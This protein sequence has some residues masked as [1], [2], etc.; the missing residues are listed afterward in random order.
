MPGRIQLTL[1]I[2]ADSS[3][4]KRELQG[5]Q[6]Q[7]QSISSMKMH[8]PL[9]D[10]QSDIAGGVKA[11][12]QLQAALATAVNKDTGQLNLSKFSRTL[13]EA[14]TDVAQLGQQLKQLGPVGEQAFQTLCSSILTADQSVRSLDGLFG[15]FLKGLGN[16]AMWTLQSNAIHAMQSALSGAYS[17]AQQL[18]KGLTDIAIVSDLTGN[19]LTNFAKTA[20]QM[21]KDLSASTRDVVSGAL[22][23]YQAGLSDEEVINRTETTIKLAQTSGESAEQISSYMTA[24]W[25]N[26]Y[27][28]SKSVEYYADAISYL[29]AVTAA[30]NADIAEGMQAFSAVA[31][32]VGLSFEYGASALTLLRDIT[33]QSAS[34]IGNSLKT[35]FARLS[36]V[37]QGETL[38]DGVDLTKYSQSLMNV[39]VE[40]LDA[41]G[42]LKDMDTILDDL[43]E[44]WKNLDE[45]NKVALATTVGGV[46]QYNNLISLMDNYGKFQELVTGSYQ[47]E[48][49]LEEQHAKY[50]ESWAAASDRVKAAWEQIYQLL[51]NDKALIGISNTF[52]KILD[53][54][55]G[56]LEGMGGLKGI[57][58]SILGFVTRLLDTSSIRQGVDNVWAYLNP[59]KALQEEQAM[60]A[61]ARQ[62]LAKSLR[63]E[64][65]SK[66]YNTAVDSYLASVE[67]FNKEQDK[68]T[69]YEKNL[70]QVLLEDTAQRL[71]QLQLLEEQKKVLQ[72]TIALEK[73]SVSDQKAM[74]TAATQA[75]IGQDFLNLIDEEQKDY[76]ANKFNAEGTPYSGPGITM[77]RAG[78]A[79]TFLQ[80]LDPDIAPEL[81]A[82]IERYASSL[83]KGSNKVQDSI[84]QQIK[85]WI[86]TTLAGVEARLDKYPQAQKDKSKQDTKTKTETKLDKAVANAAQETAEAKEK[87]AEADKATADANQ[88]I[89][90]QEQEKTQLGQIQKDNAEQQQQEEQ[91]RHGWLSSIVDKIKQIVS[92]ETQEEQ[93]TD[94]IV[95]NQKAMS[96]EEERQ[97]QA[98]QRRQQQQRGVASM[99]YGVAA[100]S[101]LYAYTVAFDTLLEKIKEGD[102]SISQLTGTFIG[103]AGNITNAG[104]SLAMWGKALE[105]SGSAL[106]GFLLKITSSVP[107]LLGFIAVITALYFIIKKVAEFVQ[108]QDW[109]F[110]NRL[111]KDAEEA[112]DAAAE[113]RKEY[114]Q[115]NDVLSTLKD[116]N[117]AINNLKEG[118]VEWRQAVQELNSELRELIDKY[119]LV[120]GTDFN[121]NN[122][123]IEL[124]SEGQQKLNQKQHE[125]LSEAE[126][127]ESYASVYDLLNDVYNIRKN[128]VN[129]NDAW[130]ALQ[131]EASGYQNL[132]GGTDAETINNIKNLLAQGQGS[133]ALKNAYNDYTVAMGTEALQSKLAT[134]MFNFLGENFGDL[135]TDSF[136]NDMTKELLN[137]HLDELPKNEEEVK[138]WISDILP[139]LLR[140]YAQDSDFVGPGNTP[141]KP[142]KRNDYDRG[143]A[144]LT[145]KEKENA[146]QY[147]DALIKLQDE[148]QGL[149]ESEA[150]AASKAYDLAVQYM[151]FNKG[152][153]DIKENYETYIPLLR[154]A[155]KFSGDYV[156]TV[157]EL[158]N[159]L[160]LMLDI[161]PQ[162]LSDAFFES[163]EAIDAMEKAAKGSI[164]ALQELT[165]LAAQDLLDQGFAKIHPTIMTDQL[166]EQFAALQE[167]INNSEQWN[168]LEV[169]AELKLHDE[170]FI[171][172]LNA[173]IMEAYSISEEA[174]QA[175]Y[176]SIQGA[177][178][179]IQFEPDVEMRSETV[180]TRGYTAIAGQV[181]MKQGSLQD[182]VSYM[183]NAEITAETEMVIPHIN[184]A[185]SKGPV[186]KKTGLSTPKGG[187][188]GGSKQKTK[189][190]DTNRYHEITEKI[191]QTQHALEMLNDEED[192]AYGQKKLDLIQE[193]IKL[194]EQE[195]KQYKELYKE[196]QGY[197]ASDRALLA[198]KYGA[199]F[200]EDGTI[201]NYQKWYD[202]FVDKYNSGAMD[203]DA[204]KAFEDAI[205]KYEESYKKMNEA[206]KKYQE[207]LN[208]EYDARIELIEHKLEFLNKEVDEANKHIDFLIKQATKDIYKLADAMALMSQKAGNLL[209]KSKNYRDAIV[210]MFANK[211]H[212]NVSE[213]MINAFLNGGEGAPTV[214][215]LIDAAGDLTD[216][217]I[218]LLYEYADALEEISE[219]LIE[220]REQQ[221]ATL[222]EVIDGFNE[223][224][225]RQGD[226]IND[227]TEFLKHYRNVVDIVGKDIL[228]ISDEML[229]Q[230]G[231]TAVEGAKANL[232]VAKL[233]L[234]QNK[235][236]LEQMREELERER[237]NGASEEAIRLMEEQIEAQEDRV[238]EMSENWASAWEDALQAAQDAF[239]DAIKIAT[240]AFD[241]A[242]AGSMGNLDNLQDMYEKQNTLND[243]YLPKYQQIYELNKLTRDVNNAIDNTDNIAGKERLLQ[244]QRDINDAMEEGAQVSEYDVGFMQRRLE[245][246]M[247]R[248]ALEEA[249]NA[250]N[251]VRMTRDSEGNWSY[252][253]TA[254]AQKIADA[255]QNYEDKLYELEKYN[256]EH[257]KDMQDM[258]LNLLA[259]YRDDI[260]GLN[261]TDEERAQM[262]Q[263][264]W[265]KLQSEYGVFMD[266]A[267]ND[268]QFIVDTFGVYDHQ[269]M[270][271]FED[272]ILSMT[273]GFSTLEEYLEN[274]LLASQYMMGQTS[275]A[276]SDWDGDWHSIFEI[277]GV[278]AE[279][280]AGEVDEAMA[281]FGKTMEAAVDE[282][283]RFADELDE[284]FDLALDNLKEFVDEYDKEIKK[285]VDDNQRALESIQAFI[286]EYDRLHANDEEEEEEPPKTTTPTTQPGTGGS[287]SGGGGGGGSGSGGGGGDASSPTT[288]VD[289]GVRRYIDNGDSGHSYQKMMSDNTWVTISSSAHTFGA[290]YP[291]GGIYYKKCTVCGHTV[292]A[293]DGSEKKPR[294]CFDAGTKIIMADGLLKNIEDIQVG[295]L[296]IA[297]NEL[298]K[299]LE[300]QAVTAFM[301][302]HN[303]T[304]MVNIYLENG[305][306][307]GMT[308]SHPILTTTGWKSLNYE[309]ALEEHEMETEPIEI[310]QEVILAVGTSKVTK[311][312][313]RKDIENYDTYNITVSE[314]HTYI[315]NGI[316]V[317]NAN[318]AV[319]MASGGYT[320]VWGP[321]GRAAILHEKE[322]VLNRTDTENLLTT[323]GF[324]RDLTRMISV[325][326]AGA[327]AGLGNIFSGGLVQGGSFLDQNVTIHA[328]FPNAVN[329]TEI[330]EA[331]SNLIGLATQYAG[332]KK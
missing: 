127:Q 329:H 155:N 267:L 5:L 131:T 160:S 203:D 69:E 247:A 71:R 301:I 2:N 239:T 122:G 270:T 124:T 265:E 171:D 296:V 154:E 82:M 16:T 24:I 8:S 142:Q 22:I 201:K 236:I 46:R 12:Q 209:D 208:K 302:H 292:V 273:S 293:D 317:H 284:Q 109:N 204:W 245:L 299:E 275:D 167:E 218:K 77:R 199:K 210:E 86:D 44:K 93:I 220:L 248:I 277:A 73:I 261:V 96:D 212:K 200:N 182:F 322:L 91:E 198:S 18:N 147:A 243:L 135:Y 149:G 216:K 278:D 138:Q 108:Q 41:N 53:F 106:G 146:E 54:V 312:E 31:D 272:T 64:G 104:S 1:G 286:Y 223:K 177:L 99:Q 249:Q 156:N 227:T 238:R 291:Y 87:S 166:R 253:Y 17:Y 280:F 63:V 114:E 271:D 196:A 6:Q 256:Q 19:Q 285:I 134:S 283:Q 32:T 112:R 70:T 174:G 311:I 51:I 57:L 235:Q 61:V 308:A 232:A 295:E 58:P 289:T 207:L 120:Y 78:V 74:K 158:R 314:A 250:K 300:I 125:A 297:Y 128:N 165:E 262:L 244:L 29:G 194:L 303:T 233:Q 298:T 89:V 260:A 189:E 79:S 190:K 321:E 288:P 186:G 43:A 13:T 45:A 36:S 163:T 246:E 178:N 259:Q 23:Y 224:I 37:K 27:D 215:D 3:Q 141:F 179:A 30:S 222:G 72:E 330:E 268:G 15:K 157:G 118:T 81:T 231:R 225:E 180:K 10:L 50:T 274:F 90:K 187:G 172:Q 327:S 219:Q 323:V 38:E 325:N 145:K 264:Y 49:Y 197:N 33:Q 133:E 52:A 168:N 281:D 326:A 39:G 183:G 205:K 294:G 192:R 152:L 76:L 121:V 234:D 279:N 68:M 252:T 85:T 117:S 42:Q 62:E 55:G 92:L 107:A 213:K 100:L 159:D 258:M 26:F 20:N 318:T 60:K 129:V 237:A 83:G 217:E 313:Y 309:I 102:A 101:S 21:A 140:Q 206:E 4:A 230:L 148:L 132:I 139:E 111:T 119:G 320:G 56:I 75:A 153:K 263:E 214:Q 40:I 150:E 164:E 304:G 328:E 162:S 226:I 202:S 173:M 67:K 257:V 276:Y 181:N 123:R 332:R 110:P 306:I 97:L 136:L 28:G 94:D 126:A 14:R 113:A 254:D 34:T 59:Q 47:S 175:M 310:G 65:G 184:G 185:K 315:A 240:D 331:F 195:A 98:R 316:I 161:D 7:L 9:G 324:V 242:V 176:E 290:Q 266:K 191:G 48:G 170:G 143:D 25:N 35:I 251:Q 88:I 11:A 144:D 319:K 116:K 229:K 115:I 130:K 169:G 80:T 95:A 84:Y 151:N 287:G 228:G 105:G 221:Y 307:L 193:K 103:L 137:N 188:G 66:E 255:Q 269:L 305:L 211:N 241:K 282:A